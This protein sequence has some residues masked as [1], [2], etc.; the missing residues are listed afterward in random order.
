MSSR[1]L[2]WSSGLFFRKHALRVFNILSTAP[3]LMQFDA[4]IPSFHI[5]CNIVQ[6][7]IGFKCLRLNILLKYIVFLNHNI[8]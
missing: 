2:T 1:T 7:E 8:F 6:V 3:N 4:K 5:L